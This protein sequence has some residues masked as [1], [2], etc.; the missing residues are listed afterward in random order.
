MPIELRE[1]KKGPFFFLRKN[2]FCPLVLS[3]STVA[4]MRLSLPGRE[5]KTE[6][7]E[8]NH[9]FF[10]HNKK[11]GRFSVSVRTYKQEE[12]NALTP[13]ATNMHTAHFFVL[14]RSESTLTIYGH[15]VRGLL[16]PLHRVPHSLRSSIHSFVCVAREKMKQHHSGAI[17]FFSTNSMYEEDERQRPRA[18]ADQNQHGNK[19]SQ[20]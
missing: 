17:C 12:K 1:R 18:I 19:S 5:I 20:L 3:L 6:N 2:L 10:H 13:A 8:A 11:K 9:L 16:L 4:C 15:S 14:Q 7:W